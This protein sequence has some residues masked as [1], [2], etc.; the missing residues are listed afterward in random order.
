MA[1]KL[2]LELAG[3]VPKT[4]GIVVASSR[5]L[6][7]I[8]AERDSIYMRRMPFERGD[9][10]AGREV[11]KFNGVVETGRGERLAVGSE[12]DAK[13]KAPVALELRRRLGVGRSREHRGKY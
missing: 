12:S 11:P 2:T 1:F 9:L 5:D 4:D 10:F 13:N 8:G 3:F 6:V 7:A